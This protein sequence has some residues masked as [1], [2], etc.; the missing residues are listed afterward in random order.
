MTEPTEWVSAPAIVKK[1]SAKNGIRLCIDSRPLNT[2][3]KRSEYPIPTVDHL[4]TEISDAKVFSLADI[5]SA[6]WHIPLDKE[7]SLLTTFSTPLGRMKWNRMPFGISVAPE[8]FQRRIDG[9]LE[10]DGVKAIA[11]D[12]L[13][14]GDGETIEEATANNDE[15]PLTLVERCKQKNIKLSKEKFQLRKIELFY[16]GVVL[17]DKGFK[18]KQDCVQSKPATT[19]KEEVRRLLGVVTYL[20]RFSEDLSTKSEPLRT[21]LKKETALIWE[22]NEQKAFEEIKTV[23]SNAPLLKCFNPVETVEIQVDASSSGL[24][25][26]KVI[27]IY[28]MLREQ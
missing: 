23:I 7:S 10:D 26:C 18:K 12:I 19:N 27:S 5:K 25:A 9:N 15:R 21:L 14:W 11:D 17:T 24:G 2:A 13:I 22:A 28:S 16:M 20:S 1:P 6:F 3:L 4:L 8:E